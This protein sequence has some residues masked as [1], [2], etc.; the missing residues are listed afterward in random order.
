MCKLQR[1]VLICHMPILVVANV[2]IRCRQRRTASA[3][4]DV[5]EQTHRI[6]KFFFMQL[7][8]SLHIWSQAAHQLTNTRLSPHATE[9]FCNSICLKLVKACKDAM[10]KPSRDLQCG[11]SHVKNI[12]FRLYIICSLFLCCYLECGSLSLYMVIPFVNL[13]GHSEW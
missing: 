13:Y 4:F 5:N 7:P 3:N 10:R 11:P 8:P 9:L 6:Y 12:H 1:F 2:I